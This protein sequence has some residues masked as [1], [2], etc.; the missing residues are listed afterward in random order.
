MKIL[1]TICQKKV[2]DLPPMWIMR[3]AGRYLSEYRNI[4]A[5]C[6]GFLDLCYNPKLAS[7]VTLQPIR[8]FDFDAAIIF[9]D[10]LV[11]PHALG[12]EV[13]F[14][15]GEGP[16]LGDLD[17]KKLDLGR[18]VKFLEPVFENLRLT[19]DNLAA[20]KALIGFSGA[21]FTLACYMIEGGSSR[22]FAKVRRLAVENPQ[23]FS[24]LIDVLVEAVSIYLIEQAK[25]GA[26]ILKIFDSWAGILPQAEYEKWVINPIRRIC[27]KV[28]SEIQDVP[29]I[30]FPRGSGEL[31]FDFLQK[32]GEVDVLAVDQNF[33][34]DRTPD[35]VVLQGNLDNYL[36]AY[37]SKND[38]EKGVRAIFDK[39]QGRPFI[40]NLGH[41]IIKDTPIENVEFLVDLVRGC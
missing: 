33:V 7:E 18:V 2:F 39:M 29:L 11:I 16:K 15:A 19:R 10:I 12:Q 13:S 20:D 28:K 38:I 9:S 4:R 6:G 8:R 30:L 36:L 26:D 24:Q 1:E 35:N 23:Y 3:Q 25:N 34:M 31:Y 40:F 14:V 41:G 5:G 22:D 37:G 17:L 27:E 21:P 32:V